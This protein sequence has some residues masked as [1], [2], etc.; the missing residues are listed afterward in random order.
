MIS[1]VFHDHQ[2]LFLS[3]QVRT[4]FQT[5][6][7]YIFFFLFHILVNRCELEEISLE[8]N[9]AGFAALTSLQIQDNKLKNWQ[10]IFCLNFIPI[11]QGQAH[12]MFSRFLNLRI[13]STKFSCFCTRQKFSIEIRTADIP[14]YHNKKGTLQPSKKLVDWQ[15]QDS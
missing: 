13:F 4:F 11:L 2:N 10:S 14:V 8:D 6:Y 9:Q 3:Q 1:K 15:I 12:H 5:K 7:L